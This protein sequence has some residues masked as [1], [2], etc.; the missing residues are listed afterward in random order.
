MSGQALCTG[1]KARINPYHDWRHS[2]MGWDNGGLTGRGLHSFT[3]QLNIST[4]CGIRWVRDF[5]P[6]Y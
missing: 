3:F 6:V 2:G 4:F 5:P 1:E